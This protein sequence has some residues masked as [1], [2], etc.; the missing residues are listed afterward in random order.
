M[1]NIR[2]KEE[3][4]VYLQE[5][6][7][8]LDNK[9]LALKLN[10]TKSSVICKAHSL[11]LCRQNLNKAGDSMRICTVCKIE[12][13]KTAEFFTSFIG[14][15]NGLVFQSKCKVCEKKYV[16][17]VNST[18]VKTF[19]GILRNI[20]RDNKRTQKG[21]DIDLDYLLFLWEKQNHRCIISGIEMTTVKGKGVY[22]FSNVSVDRINPNLGYIKDNIQLVC[23]WANTAKSNLSMDEFKKMISITHK[24]I[25][26]M[27]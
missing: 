18:P 11:T 5:N 20:R 7:T 8:I 14:K 25:N 2:W 19:K 15:R 24:N 21:F 9:E 17:D 26:N 12:Y 6:Y 4:I 23:S 3:D 27:P 22:Y 16:Q 13:P 1:N 10:R